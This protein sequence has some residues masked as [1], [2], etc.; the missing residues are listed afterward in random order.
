[1]LTDG[2]YPTKS[3]PAA[4][5]PRATAAAYESEPTLNPFPLST[6]DADDD[7]ARR[8]RPGQRPEPEL[9]TGFD[10]P[11]AGKQR[12]MTVTPPRTDL[13][14]LCVNTI[15][16]L[17]MD[18]VQAAQSGHPGTPMALA[19]VAYR[20]WQRYLRYDPADPIW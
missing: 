4:C 16:T 12:P 1:M 2:T 6:S 17:S 9:R 3:A 20:V 7:R 11:A 8:H 13:D 14:T 5:I 10:R 15:R 18:A 19:P